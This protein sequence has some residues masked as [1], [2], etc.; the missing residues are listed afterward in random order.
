MAYT[1]PES[2]DRVT[3]TPLA[4]KRHP[5]FPLSS[6]NSAKLGHLVQLRS[7]IKPTVYIILTRCK[8]NSKASLGCGVF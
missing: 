6:M 3:A 1:L 4:V 5:D 7:H 2:N 8:A